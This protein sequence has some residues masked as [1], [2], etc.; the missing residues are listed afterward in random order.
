MIL[1]C[2]A[3]LDC[4]TAVQ[5]FWRGRLRFDIFTNMH[6]GF[7]I[8]LRKTYPK[9]YAWTKDATKVFFTVFCF[10]NVVTGGRRRGLCKKHAKPE[11][12]HPLQCHDHTGRCCTVAWDVRVCYWE[13][14]LWT[15]PRQIF[16][17]SWACDSSMMQTM[18]I[19]K[20]NT[21]VGCIL[22]HVT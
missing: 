17:E 4:D 15:T 3:V 20:F 2:Q 7:G 9:K 8:F 16:L 6:S 12:G 22:H 21:A 14:F 10:I 18:H 11:L 5:T 1:N 13:A 19:L